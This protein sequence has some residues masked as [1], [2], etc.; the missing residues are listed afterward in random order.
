MK[1][2]EYSKLKQLDRIEYLLTKPKHSGQFV[3][4][5]FAYGAIMFLMVFICMALLFY[6]QLENSDLIY[7][8]QILKDLFVKVFFFILALDFLILFWFLYSDYQHNKFFKD[9]I[10]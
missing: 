8:Y 10:K 6:A 2:K 7:S 9:K 3:S 4:F 5:N 1:N